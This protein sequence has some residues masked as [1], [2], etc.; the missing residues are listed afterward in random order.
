MGA[1]RAG[2]NL[3]VKDV[4]DI[5]LELVEAGSMSKDSI[6]RFLNLKRPK[7]IYERIPHITLQLYHNL[8]ETIIIPTEPELLKKYIDYYE[9]KS[10]IKALE[11]EIKDQ[12]FVKLE[13][14]SQERVSRILEKALKFK[15][16]S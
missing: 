4:K 2:L 16:T 13:R 11:R 15:A 5:L 10:H 9:G 3:S 1:F 6:N 14:K 8:S 12:N 7:E